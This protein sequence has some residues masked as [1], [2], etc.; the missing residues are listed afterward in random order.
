MVLIFVSCQ[1][2][3]VSTATQ[4]KEE[5]SLIPGEF[6]EG[7]LVKVDKDN[8]LWKKELSDQEYY[9]LREAGTERA[10]TGDLWDH[11]GEGTY[12]CAACGLPL[13]SSG[14]KYKSGSGWPSYYEPIK[15]EFVA[16]KKD[17]KFG[18]NRIEVLC[19]RCDGHLGHVFDDGPEPTGLRYCINS[20]SLDF[21]AEKP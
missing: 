8:Q 5:A 19:A 18:W 3:E 17:D 20:Y 9:I 10:F 21:V 16:E 14:T 7:Q 6:K 2:Q 11:K 1:G 4:I 12:V 13:F 15:E